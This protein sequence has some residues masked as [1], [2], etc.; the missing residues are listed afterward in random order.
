VQSHEVGA[1][2]QLGQIDLSHAEL[3]RMLGREEG[4]VSDHLILNPVA[5]LATIEPTLP[6]PMTPSILFVISTPMKR[7][8]SHLPACVEA[9]ACGNLPR[10]RQHQRD[11]VLGGRDRIC[12]TACS[13]R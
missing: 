3:R 12:R 8:F 13:S 7:F 9:S 1:P 6:Q 5:R 10:E 2:E 11:R 4:I